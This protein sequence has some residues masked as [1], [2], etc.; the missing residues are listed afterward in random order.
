MTCPTEMVQV[1][2]PQDDG[3]MVSFCIDRLEVTNADYLHFLANAAPTP[4]TDPLCG[5][6]TTYEPSV[7]PDASDALFP[8]LGV[9]WCDAR[10]YCKAHKK[11]LCGNLFGG[12]QPTDHLDLKDDQWFAACSNNNEAPYPYGTTDASFAA[13][14][15]CD[16]DAGCDASAP[17][18]PD[19]AAVVGSIGTC[20]GGVPGLFDMS[21]NAWEWQDSCSDDGLDAGKHAP[22]YDH[23]YRRGGGYDVPHVADGGG[24]VSDKCLACAAC[25]SGRTQRRNRPLDTGL[26]CCLD[27][28]P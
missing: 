4:S 26:R 2:V 17:I 20:E 12:A 9:D 8:V 18:G 19:A 24:N 15:D 7:H 27:L 22:E 11:R 1:D 23:C 14:R 28:S 3:A 16:P 13:C 5:W 21:G 10:D 25:S 6:N